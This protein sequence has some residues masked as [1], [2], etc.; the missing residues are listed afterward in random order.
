[1]GTTQP[2]VERLEVYDY[3]ARKSMPGR[4]LDSYLAAKFSNYSRSF[5]TQLVRRGKVTINDKQVKPHHEI[6]KGDRLHIELPVFAK[7]TLTPEN[8]PIDVIHE[9][10][11]ILVINKAA[12]I[13]VH[14]A[15]SHTSG[16]LVN[17]LVY[18]CDSLPD[19]DDKVR[20][21]IVHRLDRDTTGV[22][23]VVKD[24]ASR[25]WIGRQFEWRRVKKSYIAVVEGEPELDSDLI[26]LP[27]GRHKYTKEKM[28]V[29]LE[30]GRQAVSIYTVLERFDGFSHVRVEPRTGRTHQIRVHMAAIGH[31]VVCD[32]QYGRRDVL[33]LS[34]LTG[35]P[36]HEG[37]PPIIH[38]QA[39]HA[40]AITF[41]HPGTRQ[42]ATYTAPL[43]PDIQCLLSALRKYRAK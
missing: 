26:E 21:G 41:N 22:M 6:K 27:L 11:H 10:E 12:G 32:A 29:N 25:G 3:S 9:D 40:H 13:I 36:H 38:R 20:P 16:T 34:E 28:S 18:Y 37:E 31:P 42:P 4:R 15:R 39:L 43:P 17:A 24:E 8:I 7:A 2:N 14:P 33:Y 35:E 19:S 1:M 5:L 23:V 30:E